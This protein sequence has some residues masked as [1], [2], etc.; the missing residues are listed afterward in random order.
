MHNI[1]L[2]HFSGGFMES[3]GMSSAGENGKADP[4]GTGRSPAAT[5]AI[6]RA[7]GQATP[8]S[9]ALS[10]ANR[11]VSKP[12]APAPTRPA[13]AP[14]APVSTTNDPAPSDSSASSQ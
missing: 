13:P 14:P 12:A 6:H 5:Q 11:D 8:A 4:K 2:T 7:V 1:Y 9:A 3:D 10:P